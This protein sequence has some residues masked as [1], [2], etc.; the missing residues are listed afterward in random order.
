MEDGKSSRRGDILIT[1]KG[2]IAVLPLGDEGLGRAA[3][4]SRQPSG[5]LAKSHLPSDHASSHSPGW[6]HRDTEALEGLKMHIRRA[7]ELDLSED[8]RFSVRK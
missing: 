7:L 3:S 8:G 5:E 1:A 2:A 4:S 6:L